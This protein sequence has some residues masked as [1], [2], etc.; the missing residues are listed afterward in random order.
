M[1]F[2]PLTKLLDGLTTSKAAALLTVGLFGV[3]GLVEIGRHSAPSAQAIDKPKPAVATGS[4]SADQVQSIRDIVKT[5]LMD[6]PEIML[7]VSKELE[8]K[9]DAIKA[10][11]A[12]KVIAEHKAALF[13]GRHDA[14]IGNPKGDVTV[15]EFFDYNCGWCKRAV[16]DIVTLVK[17]DPKVRV[18]M[19]E[20][21]IFGENSA[22]AAKAAMAAH[23][24]GKYWELH[25]ALMKEKQVTKENVFAIAQ[26]VP[27]LN[28]AKLRAD[29]ADP[30]FDRVLAENQE[31]AQKLGIEGTPAFLVD[32]RINM[33]YVPA[34]GLQ[35]LLAEVRKAGCQVC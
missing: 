20:F 17:A 35:A 4:F 9:Q 23:R 12:K 24:Q 29:I 11:E 26:K 25:V 27:G 13:S 32:N 16:D 10:A 2:A 5:Y 1:A 6:H 19:K 15:I 7:E 3:L 30:E 33:G 8:K 18:V 21:P 28:I 31:L 14:V 22:I 34:A